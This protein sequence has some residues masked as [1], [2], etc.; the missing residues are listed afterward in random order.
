MDERLILST[1]LKQYVFASYYTTKALFEQIKVIITK[2]VN[3]MSSIASRPVLRELP[4]V[5]TI[6]EKYEKAWITDKSLDENIEAFYEIM[7]V[8]Q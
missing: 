3:T 6:T 7:L 2:Q 4:I 5:I 1:P 8:Q